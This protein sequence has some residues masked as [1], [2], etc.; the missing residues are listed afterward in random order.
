MI[1]LFRL[2]KIPYWTD[3]ICSGWIFRN[4][5]SIFKYTYRGKW[6][7]LYHDII[8]INQEQCTKNFNA[9]TK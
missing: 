6:H 7:H 1:I 5:F 2:F 8:P 3:Y 4:C 9:N